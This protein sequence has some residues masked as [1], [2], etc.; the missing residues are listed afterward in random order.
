[1]DTTKDQSQIITDSK[2]KKFYE[3]L[4][5]EQLDLIIQANNKTINLINSIKSNR[6]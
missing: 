1:M 6:D 5:N 4:S 2:I 3:S